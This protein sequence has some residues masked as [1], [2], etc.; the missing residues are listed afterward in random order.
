MA[1]D[2]TRLLSSLDRMLRGPAAARE[3][4]AVVSRVRRHLSAHAASALAWEPIP[5]SVYG[6]ALPD[7]IRSSWVFILRAHTATGAERHPNSVQRMVAW[8]GDGDFQTKSGAAWESHFLTS[9]LSAP[10]ARRWITIPVDV[11]HQGV[12]PARDWVVVSFHT[13]PEADLIE[14]RD[15][16]SAVEGRVYAGRHAH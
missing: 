12:V 11:W 5:L 2:E 3:I 7:E 4:A 8:E 16:G 6:P 1:D 9:D 14:E 13:A 15:T 10:L